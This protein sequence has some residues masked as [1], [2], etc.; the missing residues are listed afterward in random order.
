MLISG[1][2]PAGRDVIFWYLPLLPASPPPRFTPATLWLR[3]GAAGGR[4]GGGGGR[5]V[6]RAASHVSGFRG[7]GSGIVRAGRYTIHRRDRT[8]LGREGVVREYYFRGCARRVQDYA[9]LAAGFME[10]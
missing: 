10:C 8:L 4:A 2:V 5:V 7:E 6:F 3:W 1:I 9:G